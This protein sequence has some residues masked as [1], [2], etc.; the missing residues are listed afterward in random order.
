MKDMM[1]YKG[2]FG[3]IEYSD[4]DGVFFGEIEFIRALV[5]FEGKSVE[6]LREAFKEAVDDYLDMCEQNGMTP[7]KPFKGS[8]NVRTGSELHQ[9]AATYAQNKETTLNQLVVAALEQYLDG[10]NRPRLHR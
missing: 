7:E 2:Y 4:E 8:F 1:K 6:S 10:A 9:R 5:T 3:S